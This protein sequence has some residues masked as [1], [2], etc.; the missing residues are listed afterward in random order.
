[1]DTHTDTALLMATHAGDEHAARELYVRLAPRLLGAMKALQ[2]DAHRAEDAVHSAFL[3]LL[4][5]D[6]DQAAAIRDPLAWLVRSARNA[7]LNELRGRDRAK[8]REHASARPD[9]AEAL[10]RTGAASA[11]GGFDDLLRALS[12]LADDDRELLILKHIAGLTLDQLAFALDVNRNTLASR[13]RVALD[14]L[15]ALIHT[16]EVV[17]VR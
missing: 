14:R 3:G 6:A 9:R 8:A 16:Q 11:S 5:L 7:A 2:R 1:M 12:K 13:L 10:E 15:H 4:K 17:H